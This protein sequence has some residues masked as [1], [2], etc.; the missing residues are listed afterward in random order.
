MHI[1]F[2][3]SQRTSRGVE[4]ELEIVDLDTSDLVGT[5]GQVAKIAESLGAGVMCSR[6]HP[7]SDRATHYVAG[8][9]RYLELIPPLIA[10][11]ACCQRAVAAAHDG[12]LE[13]VVDVLVTEMRDGLNL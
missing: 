1:E 7:I 3:P 9:E 10:R 2:T 4:W 12:A 13:P 8:E 5:V 11:G 6:T